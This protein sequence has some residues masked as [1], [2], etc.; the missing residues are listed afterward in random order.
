MDGLYINGISF[1][2]LILLYIEHLHTPQLPQEDKGNIM[3]NA[4]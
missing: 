3:K 1:V 4:F 2:Q